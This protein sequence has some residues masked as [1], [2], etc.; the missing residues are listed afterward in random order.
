M[1]AKLQDLTIDHFRNIRSKAGALLVVLPSDLSKL[2][3]EERQHLL[4]LENAM[5][6]QEIS[7]AVYFAIGSPE[8]DVIITE[9]AE[10]I[11][12]NDLTKSAAEAILGSIAANGYQFV[13][14]PGTT[15]IKQD[16]KVATIQ[17]HLSGYSPDGKVPTIAVVAHYDSFGV[18][19]VSLIYFKSIFKFCFFTY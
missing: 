11:I 12:P 18:A 9:V 10:N 1:V 2:N 7:I 15:S 8:L 6:V 14:S 16:I 19:P 13:V 17:G 3:T 4:L 5:L